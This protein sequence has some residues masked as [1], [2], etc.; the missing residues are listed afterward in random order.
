[1]CVTAMAAGLKRNAGWKMDQAIDGDADA[2]LANCDDSICR[3]IEVFADAA[4]KFSFDA[5]SE[6]F[7]DIHLPAGDLYTHE[8]LL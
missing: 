2:I 3:A 8:D 6:R 4:L 7:A 1:M 5:G